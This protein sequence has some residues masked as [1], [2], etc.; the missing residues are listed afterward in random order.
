MRSTLRTSNIGRF[1]HGRAPD[2]IVGV[3][4]GSTLAMF[5]VLHG[6]QHQLSSIPSWEIFAGFGLRV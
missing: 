2:A 5:Q 1:L 4:N 6:P 3:A